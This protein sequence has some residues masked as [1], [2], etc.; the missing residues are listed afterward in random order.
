M[1]KTFEQR[2]NDPVEAQMPAVDPGEVGLDAAADNIDMSNKNDAVIVEFDFPAD[3]A[4]AIEASAAELG[5]STDEWITNVLKK[6]IREKKCKIN[7]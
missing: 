2:E 7:K 6:I 3:I 5:I 1:K 4:D